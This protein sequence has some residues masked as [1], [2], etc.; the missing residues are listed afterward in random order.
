MNLTQVVT[1]LRDEHRNVQNYANELGK[2]IDVL[3][4]L[5]GTSRLPATTTKIGKLTGA[6]FLYRGPG[7]SQPPT[8]RTLSAAGRKR[9]ALAQKARWAKLRGMGVV[10]KKGKAA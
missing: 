10:P 3:A 8:K 5:T 4:T 9:I 7:Q 1:Q 2:T 6:T